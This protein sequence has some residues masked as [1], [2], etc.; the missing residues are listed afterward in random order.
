M[1]YPGKSVLTQL[2]QFAV[3]TETHSVFGI[4]GKYFKQI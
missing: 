2:A 3:Y 4:Q 1:F